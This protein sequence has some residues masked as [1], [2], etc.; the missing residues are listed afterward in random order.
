MTKLETDWWLEIEKNYAST[1][2][3]RMELFEKHGKSVLD[4]L[5]GSELA[6][7]E[8]MEMALQFY[9][10]RYPKYFSLQQDATEGFIFINRILNTATI[11]KDHHP[12]QVLLR[13]I[14][15]DF[16]IMI[17]DPTDGYYYLRGGIICSSLGWSLGTKMGMQLKEIHDPIPDYKEKMEFSMDR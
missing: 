16:A 12:L 9:C 17:R 10:A 6:A 3:L 8:L 2:K 1:V 15:E 11:V 14:P 4:H 7:K 13:N 5:P